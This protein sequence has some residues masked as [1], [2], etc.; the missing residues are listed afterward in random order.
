M[1]FQC[2]I[3]M[4]IQ[5]RSFNV[6]SWL[7]FHVETTSG[8]QRCIP[9]CFP[10]GNNIRVTTLIQRHGFNVV[11]TSHSDVETTSWFQRCMLAC[12][13]RWNNIRVSTL[14]LDLFSTSKQRQ[15]SN[16][17][18]LSD[19]QHWFSVRFPTLLQCQGFNVDSTSY[20]VVDSMSGVQ[21]CILTCFQRWNK[22]RFQHQFS[23]LK[24]R[25]S[26]T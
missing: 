14:Y 18:S 5:C 22:A 3:P 6:V 12:F 8:F 15:G 16:V 25:H 24:W 17:D 21:R 9:G 4:L 26:S 7:D 10:R 1:L 13:Q 19:F 11:S 23:T 20:S 2:H